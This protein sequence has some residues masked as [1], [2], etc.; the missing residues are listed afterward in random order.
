MEE[1]VAG[2][3][4]NEVTTALSTVVDSSTIELVVVNEAG[5]VESDDPS[6]VVSDAKVFEE[7]V[8]RVVEVES[9]VE[10]KIELWVES[11]S[12]TLES[13]VVVVKAELEVKTKE[14]DGEEFGL[15]G[16]P[17][18]LSDAMSAVRI[19]YAAMVLTTNGNTEKAI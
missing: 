13:M 7:D 12:S 14:I 18:T 16:L 10:S 15:H 4:D 2:S 5:T 9:S 3:E 6:R 17:L 19:N 11:P 8:S 1:V